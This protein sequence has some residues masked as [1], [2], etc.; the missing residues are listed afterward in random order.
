MPF[1]RMHYVSYHSYI[2]I[3]TV[4]FIDQLM[5]PSAGAGVVKFLKKIVNLYETTDDSDIDV[6][7]LFLHT[8]KLII[9]FMMYNK[10]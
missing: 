4:Q 3:I 5:L 8:N 2:V 7:C 6:C 10:A 1:Q 9:F